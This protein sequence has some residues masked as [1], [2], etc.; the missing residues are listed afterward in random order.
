MPVSFETNF[1]GLPS[2]LKCLPHSVFFFPSSYW[3]L[4][5]TYLALF[6]VVLHCAFDSLHSM[7]ASRF[8][9]GQSFICSSYS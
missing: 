2:L 6:S 1:L 5:V 8:D 7:G 4:Q 3:L 9:P